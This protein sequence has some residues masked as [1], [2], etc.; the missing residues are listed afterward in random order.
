MTHLLPSWGWVLIAAVVILNVIGLVRYGKRH[1]WHGILQTLL[2][3]FSM[4]LLGAGFALP[5]AQVPL[6]VAVGVVGMCWA[7]PA[8]RG[9]ESLFDRRPAV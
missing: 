5:S 6:F 9:R 7:I 3:L 4:A 2:Q 1:D 8:A